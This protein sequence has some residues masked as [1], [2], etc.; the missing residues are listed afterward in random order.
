MRLAQL[1]DGLCP[2][3]VDGPTDRPIRHITHDSRAAQPDGIY[4]AIRGARVDG[5]RFTPGLRVA[6]IVCDGPVA[7]EDGVTVITVDDTRAA[8]AAL[9]ANLHGRPADTVPTVGVTGTNGKTTVCWMLEQIAL[10]AGRTPGVMGT[11]G[12]R[13]GGVPLP[14][15]PLTRFTTPESPVLQALLAEMRDQGCDLIAMEASSIGLHAHRSDQVPFRAA[16]FTSFSRDHLDYH[17]TEDAYLA[18]KRRMFSELVAPDGTAVLFGDD[19][20]I[21]QTPSRAA[22]TWRYS[23]RDPGADIVASYIADAITGVTAAVKTPAGSGTLRLGLVGQH[24]LE[25]ALAALGGALAVGISLDDA[26]AGLAAL[27]D[28]P[29]RLQRVSDPAGGRHVFVDYAHTPDALER[30]LAA[31]RPLTPGRIVT[32]FGCGGDRD[33]GKR[34]LMGAA[35]SAGSDVVVVTS[36]NP[37]SEDPDAIIAD[38]LGGVTGSVVVEADRAAA[39][40]RAL[41]DTGAEDVVLIA[42]KGHETTQTIGSRKLPFSDA[43]VAAA[44]L[45]RGETP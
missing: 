20:R 28:I 10:S 35:A 4:V 25:N 40:A 2:L 31:L 14:D 13:I 7:S 1:L 8:M 26:L 23:L 45:N 11:T 41:Q 43:A 27:G 44:A 6:A 15:G 29:G 24:N 32:V 3:R 12:H 16:L 21:A 33:A 18:A 34:P 36:D 39:I 38:I 17:G 30:V 19:P 42:G 37:R 9:A 5:R 22:R